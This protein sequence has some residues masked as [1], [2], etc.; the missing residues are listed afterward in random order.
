[1]K[2]Y[3]NG[4]RI[5][6]RFDS[7]K[8]WVGRTV[9]QVF[10][11]GFIA[12]L[13]AGAY[14]VAQ[15]SRIQAVVPEVIDMTPQKIAH[16]KRDLIQRLSM[17]ENPRQNP[18]LIVYDNNDKGTLTGQN[19]PS[20]GLLMYKISTARDTP[21]ANNK[22]LTDQEVILMVMDK[23]RAFNL[24]EEI[25]FSGKD[26]KGIDHWHRCSVKLNLETEVN[27]IKKLGK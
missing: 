27:I 25:I 17:C 11:V 7:F 26:A 20:I 6:G 13:G 8:S 5:N 2:I 21:A 3:H 24:A 9:K 10:I 16:L 19:L 4:R 1:M 23:E 18:G 14:A 22:N 15:P 12:L